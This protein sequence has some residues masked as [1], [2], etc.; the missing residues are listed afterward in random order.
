[1]SSTTDPNE[2]KNR[3]MQRIIARTRELFLRDAR[4]RGA[5]VLETAV[6]WREGALSASEL[7]DSVHAYAHALR[8]VALT[9]GC[10]R[11]HELSEEAINCSI[12]HSGGWNEE[13]L[14]GLIRMLTELTEEVERE[15]VKAEEGGSEH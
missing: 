5:V 3:R 7:G 4:Q 1:M 15:T 6:Q 12:Q 13:A 2:D 11:V 14:Q 9:V 10:G 8:G